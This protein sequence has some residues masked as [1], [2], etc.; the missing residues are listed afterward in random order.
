MAHFRFRRSFGNVGS[1]FRGARPDT[2]PI[3][4]LDPDVQAF[5]EESG[6]TDLSGLNN[7]VK[8]LKGEGLYDDFVI[9]PKIGNQNAGSGTT[10]Y[11]LGGLTT[12]NK[13]LINTP[14]WNATT[15]ITY[16]GVSEYDTAADFLA[17]D[18]TTIFARLT[19]LSLG[20]GQ[21]FAGQ[22]DFAADKRN[23]SLRATG[24]DQVLLQRS[25][26]GTSANLEQ[27]GSTE[28]LAMVDQCLVSQWVNGGGRS[29][30]RNKTALTMSLVNGS[31]QTS[32]FNTD[33]LITG[34]GDATGGGTANVTY[35]A[36]AYLSGALPTTTQ[37]ETITDL[38]NAL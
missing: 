23:I 6:A 8:Y 1:R 2:Y 7:L 22:Y 24:T 28:T 4:T 38:I 13:T 35:T 5:K 33:A 9:Y 3:T 18:T 25:S 15:G 26:D 11:S 27:Y 17:N 34:A 19:P 12:N 14:T 30:W 21:F 16:D 36:E 20:S 37:R 29:A 32:G 10:V 31:A